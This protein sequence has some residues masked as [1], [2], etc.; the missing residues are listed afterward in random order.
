MTMSRRRGMALAWAA[1]LGSLLVVSAKASVTVSGVFGD[2]MVLQRGVK[3]PVWGWAEPGEKITLA[4]HG[5]TNSATA[6]AEGR[7]RVE[8]APM[9]AMAE[10][11]ELRVSGKNELLFKNVVVG[12]V[13]LCS[14]QSN[15][16]FTMGGAL[17]ADKE[18]AA[19]NYPLIRQLGVPCRIDAVPQR[20]LQASWVVCSPQTARDFTAVGYF[21]G[22]ELHRKLGVPIGLIN[23][24]WGGSCIEPFT[25]PDG[26]RAVSNAP[27]IAPIVKRVNESDPTLPEGHAAF[28]R[29]MAEF[30]S[31]LPQAEAAVK[32]GTYP[33][34]APRVPAVGVGDQ[35][36]CM[37]CNAMIAP[38]APYALRGAIWYQGESNAGDGMAYVDKTKALVLGWRALWGAEIPCYHVQLA[39]FGADWAMFRE[40]QTKI[41]DAIPRT[42]MAVT[43]DI[44]AAADIHPRNKQDVGWRL[45]QWALAKDYGKQDVVFSGPICKS[46]KAEGGKVVLMFDSVGK[47]LLA[48][49]KEGLA[50]V[51]EEASG[52]LDEFVIAGADK[53]W[54]KAEAKIEGNA[55]V[56]ASPEVKE[57]VAVRYAYVPCP[58]GRLLYNRDGLPAVPFRTDTW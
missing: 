6:D 20:T 26:F 2:N 22:L 1:V 34:P 55:V 46:Q 7:W 12:E 21:F 57:P 28:E 49:V 45:A 11:A 15:M 53:K 3:V 48:G 29:A 16:Q 25:P 33:P 52:T 38:L 24:S 43:T 13:W 56:V 19:A 35:D 47:G 54:V 42:G 9:E 44:G 27:S 17:D 4:F 10:G 50:P 58:Q 40:A 18:A 5:Q 51:K 14:G 32:A 41:M 36:P 30:K 31:W 37:K 39:G 23:A 8:L